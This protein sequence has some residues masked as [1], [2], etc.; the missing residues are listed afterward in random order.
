[1]IRLNQTNKYT[2]NTAILLILPALFA[3][4][5]FL[6]II[7]QTMQYYSISNRMTQNYKTRTAS[8]YLTEKFQEYDRS[9]AV[10]VTEFQ[11]IPAISFTD[12]NNH[13]IFLYA[14]EGYLR[15]SVLPDT[16]LISPDT[17]QKI[18]ELTQLTIEECTGNLYR[19][20]LT[21]S[22]GITTPIYLSLNAN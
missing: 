18:V 11:G 3:I 1:M 5:S 2:L 9:G 12:E 15:E 10:S 16:T 4:T 19:F 14:Y 7:T 21:D 13:Q 22:S 6:V 17:G 20:T 8:T